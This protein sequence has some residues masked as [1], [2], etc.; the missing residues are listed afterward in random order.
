MLKNRLPMKTLAVP[1]S[2]ALAIHFQFTVN[3]RGD[4]FIY[5]IHQDAAIFTVSMYT[6]T[7]NNIFLTI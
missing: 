2:K 7:R 1:I 5:I 6:P 4:R 3:A